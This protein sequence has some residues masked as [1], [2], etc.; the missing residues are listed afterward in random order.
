M[1][2]KWFGVVRWCNRDIAG[3]LMEMGIPATQENIAIVRC[4]CENNHHFTDGMIE[5]GWCAIEETIERLE[6]K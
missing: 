5:A 2:D 4:E 3:K 1:K 6:L